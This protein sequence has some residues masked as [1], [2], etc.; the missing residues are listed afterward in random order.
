MATFDLGS[1]SCIE[2]IY[3]TDKV[4]L[5]LWWWKVLYNQELG[6]HMQALV[7]KFKSWIAQTNP[8]VENV[9]KNV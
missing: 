6:Y 5:R 7:E 8:A 1:S 9:I 3:N 2:P 4:G